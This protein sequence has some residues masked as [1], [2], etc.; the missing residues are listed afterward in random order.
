M[1]DVDSMDDDV[2]LRSVQDR[3]IDTVTLQQ[4]EALD[5]VEATGQAVVAGIEIAQR[6]FAAY[7]SERVRRDLDASQA[8]LRCRS[9]DELCRLQADYLRVAV[10]QFSDE[11]ARLMRLGTEITTWSLERVR[12]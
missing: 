12:P 11:A 1:Q 5:S 7:L 9:V 8:L 6:E 3:L 2:E 10:G 4:Q